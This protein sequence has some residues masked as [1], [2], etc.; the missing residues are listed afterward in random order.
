MGLVLSMP[1]L[2][3]LVSS[4]MIQLASCASIFFYTASVSP[5]R[6]T[7]HT[8]LDHAKIGSPIST[9]VIRSRL[10]HTVEGLLPYYNISQFSHREV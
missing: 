6:L 4:N 3:F 7:D 9:Q 5:R 2:N 1:I 10:E 8:V